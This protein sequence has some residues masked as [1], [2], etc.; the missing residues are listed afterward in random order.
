MEE[1][2][3]AL[4]QRG[5]D[6]VK[7]Q[8]QLDVDGLKKDFESPWQPGVTDL[9]G[10]LIADSC[11][12]VARRAFDVLSSDSWIEPSIWRGIRIVPVVGE[13][14]GGTGPIGPSQRAP[15]AIDLGLARMTSGQSAIAE[16]ILP[17]S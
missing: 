14:P 17:W 6:L 8:V 5:K 3:E 4:I 13:G 9:F 7:K 2:V 12:V 11:G 16:A 1:R 15:H 10:R